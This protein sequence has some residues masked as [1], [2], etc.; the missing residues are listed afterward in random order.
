VR[1]TTTPPVLVQ[2]VVASSAPALA[3]KLWVD[4]ANASAAKM[5]NTFI[6]K[7]PV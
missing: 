6:E 5:I 2:W 4:Q 7:T 3:A 1:T